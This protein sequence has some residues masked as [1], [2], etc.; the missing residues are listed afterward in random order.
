MI[1]KFAF[2]VLYV[3]KVFD[4][5]GNTF[6]AAIPKHRSFWSGEV[7]LHRKHQDW[8][9]TS[10]QLFFQHLVG[11]SPRWHCIH[12]MDFKLLVSLIS[13]YILLVSSRCFFRTQGD[14]SPLLGSH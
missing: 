7:Q 5:N 9:V 6:R 3:E 11:G 1:I 10:V 12:L 14:Y 13:G 4:E 2:H 8:L